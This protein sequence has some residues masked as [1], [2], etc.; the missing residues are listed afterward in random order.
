MTSKLYPKDHVTLRK[1]SRV[2]MNRST[3]NASLLESVSKKFVCQPP[4]KLL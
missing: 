3:M 1:V 2:Q 4:P